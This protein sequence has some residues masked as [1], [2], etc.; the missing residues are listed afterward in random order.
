M[1]KKLAA[2]LSVIIL[3]FALS[4]GAAAANLGAGVVTASAINFR[5]APSTGSA[6]LAVIK[7]GTEVVV[8]DKYN[9]SWYKVMVDGVEGY[10]HSSY[11]ELKP[12]M[13]ILCGEARITGDCVRLRSAPSRTSSVLDYLYRTDTAEVLGVDGEWYK[14]VCNGKQGYVSS[15]YVKPVE[16]DLSVTQSIDYVTVGMKIA[17]DARNYLDVPYV[18]GGS[19]ESGFDCSGF[20]YFLFKKFGFDDFNRT[21]SSQWDVSSS[22]SKDELEIGDL[23]FFSSTYSTSVEHVGLYIG[24]GQFIHSS[25]GKGC[26]TI[27]SMADWYYENHYYGCVHVAGTEL[28]AEAE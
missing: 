20:T 2:V 25:S 27:N 1:K 21:A 5:E 15:D 11:V 13:D 4:T 3:S 7:N 16:R 23:V 9:A 22:V 28:P 12:E 6:V 24:D 14:V 17:E 26:V 10:M 8:V 18:Y 19:S